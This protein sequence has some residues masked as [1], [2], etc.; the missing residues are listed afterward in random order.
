MMTM[1]ISFAGISLK[2][3]GFG[4][5]VRLRQ[6][7]ELSVVTRGWWKLESFLRRVRVWLRRVATVLTNVGESPTSSDDDDDDDVSIFDAF[8]IST[9]PYVMPGK[10]TN[11]NR[12]F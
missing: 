9:C 2:S 11:K 5:R 6:T 10:L 7:T 8:K 4:T 3:V 12:L 1:M